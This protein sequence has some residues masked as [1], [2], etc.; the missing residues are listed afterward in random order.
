[1]FTGIVHEVGTVVGVERSRQLVR[2]TVAAPKTAARLESLDSVAVHGVCLTV[3]ERA[4]GAMRFEVIPETQQVT[5]LG[6]IRRG[7]RVHLEPSL[8]LC[9]R[10][11]GHVLLGH[12]DGTG[13]ILTRQERGGALVWRLRVAQALR[14]LL[15]PKGP[16]AL[17][18]VSLTVGG[19]LTGATVTVHLIPETLRQTTF[20]A[21][22]VGDRVNIE[23]DYLAKLVRHFLHQRSTGG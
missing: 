6:T 20:A 18:G 4:Q 22:R 23:L 13:T 17:D 11:G 10:L 7:D 9:D 5:T 1:M 21:R 16:V 3:I 2:L 19:A 14:R 8:R 12:V 15:V